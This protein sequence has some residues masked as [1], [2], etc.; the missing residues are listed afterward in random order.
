MKT[1]YRTKCY[2]CGRTG[3][4]YS[5]GPEHHPYCMGCLPAPPGFKV[6]YN[7]ALAVM[8]LATGS[9]LGYLFLRTVAAL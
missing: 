7:C 6:L 2:S 8:G 3:D 4:A 5:F 9:F 1:H